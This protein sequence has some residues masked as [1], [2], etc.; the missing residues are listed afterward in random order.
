MLEGGVPPASLDL[1]ADRLRFGRSMGGRSFKLEQFHEG[2]NTRSG[3]GPRVEGGTVKSVA[4]LTSRA[5][6]C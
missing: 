4:Y 3:L 1:G 6:S 5:E 2:G